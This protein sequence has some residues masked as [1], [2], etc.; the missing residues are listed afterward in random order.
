MHL[1]YNPTV[2]LADLHHRQLQQ[3]KKFMKQLMLVL[4][5]CFTLEDYRSWWPVEDVCS[6]MASQ[7]HMDG[8]TLHI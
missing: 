8:M 5:T 7:V 6:I 2:H 4:P 1:Q 3:L